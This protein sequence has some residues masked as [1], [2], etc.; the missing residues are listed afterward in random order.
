[1]LASN[2][3][4]EKSEEIRDSQTA[5]FCCATRK[6]IIA[7]ERIAKNARQENSENGWRT[8]NIPAKT[9]DNGS[10]NATNR[11]ELR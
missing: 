4:S 6:S 11:K 8:M 9:Q 5:P 7:R 1:M 3:G 10:G 2:G